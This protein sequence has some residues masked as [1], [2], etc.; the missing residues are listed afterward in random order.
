MLHSIN[1]FDQSRIASY[2]LL[3]ETEIGQRLELAHRCY[4]QHRESSFE[5]RA[6][7][8][9][10]LA[11]ILE[12]NSEEYSKLMS[13]EMGKPI[14]QARAEI[15]KSAWL[16]RFYA[17]KGAEFLQD[18]YVQTDAERS[19][20]SYEPLG[21][22]LAIMPWNYPWW[23]VLRFAVPALMAGN[24][25]LLKHAPNVQGT[26]KH[27]IA[28]FEEAG[29]AKGCLQNLPVSVEQVASLISDPIVKAVTLTGSGKAGSAVA[30]QAGKA[31]KKT[32]LELGGSNAFIVLD[33]ADLDLAVKAGL[34]ARMQNNGQSCIAAK[35]FFLQEGIAEEYLHRFAAGMQTYKSGN[36][37][38]ESTTLGPLARLDL[39]ED[40][41][42]QVT[43]SLQEGA[44]LMAGGKR[45]GAFYEPTILSEAKPGMTAFEE[46]LFG[47]VAAI[48]VVSDLDEAI[49]LSN[50]SKF[51]LGASIFT[52][53][54][55]TAVQASRKLEDGAVFINE[56]VKSD[57]RLPFGGT[58]TSGYGRELSQHGIREFC[59]AKTVYVKG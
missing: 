46:E 18:E 10:A 28:A 21:A 45:N 7:K 40:L 35:R 31:I 14:A 6:A 57:P 17:E 43:Q 24:V 53:D 11:G 39:A 20:V 36:P 16:C 47:P 9:L 19:W 29:F 3:T 27:I 5:S 25:G 1:P 2:P 50:L 48:T 22:V 12:K 13:L 58:K 33:D 37:L 59:N 51:G 8:L 15:K 38:E 30:A 23:Q 26:A 42:R 34:N 4:F 55:A 32:V 54:V 44:R 52:Q 49:K 56:L 41:E